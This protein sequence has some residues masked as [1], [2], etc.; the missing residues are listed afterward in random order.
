LPGPRGGFGDRA[1]QIFSL[2]PAVQLGD[3]LAVAAGLHAGRSSRGEAVAWV[4][5]G[6]LRPSVRVVGGLETAVEVAR[7][8]SA[9]DDGALSALRAEVGYRVDAGLRFAAGYTVLGFSGLGLS[10]ETDESDRLYLRA[11]VAY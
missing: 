11:E 9:S 4:W 6:T 7:R 5:T 10:G 1:L 8:T 2:L 3:R